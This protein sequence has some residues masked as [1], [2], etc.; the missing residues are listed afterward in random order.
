VRATRRYAAAVPLTAPGHSAA[1]K[2]SGDLA[3]S[4]W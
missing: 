1:A 3:G 2:E 4:Q